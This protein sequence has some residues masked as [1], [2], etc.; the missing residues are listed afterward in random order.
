MNTRGGP[1]IVLASV[2]YGFGIIGGELFVTLTLAAL[3]TSL[4]SGAWFRHLL[5][6]GWPLYE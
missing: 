5:R 2:A 4:A 3:I 6:R 1:G